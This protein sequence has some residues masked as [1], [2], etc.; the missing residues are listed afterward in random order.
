MV[1]NGEMIV[2]Y[3]GTIERGARAHKCPAEKKRIGR[4]SL[5]GFVLRVTPD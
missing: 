5:Y 3:P 4:I 2:E 1:M